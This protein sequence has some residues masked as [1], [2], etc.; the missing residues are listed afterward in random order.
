[1]TLIIGYI[2]KDGIY[3]GGDSAGVGS[4]FTK[5]IRKDPK[6][7]FIGKNKEFIIGFTTSFR[8]GQLLM[9]YNP[10]D[11]KGKAVFQYMITD[12][13][14]GLREHLKAGGY[15]MINSGKEEGG[16]F[17]V[18]Y[19]NRLFYIDGSFQIEES[20]MPYNACGCAY[21]LALGALTGIESLCSKEM[22]EFFNPVKK[23]RLAFEAALPHSTGICK[24]FKILKLENKKGE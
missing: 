24:P 21:E 4:N 2:A 14:D 23:L 22:N 17:L 13:I 8:M 7:F 9:S 16:T 3:M 18:G 19:E 12:F 10:P 11:R 6:V 20:S 5:T 1:M 15:L